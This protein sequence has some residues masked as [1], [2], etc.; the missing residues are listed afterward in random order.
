MSLAVTAHAFPR[1]IVDRLVRRLDR[2]LA[3]FGRELHVPLIAA[4]AYYAGA[5]AAFFVGTLS[6]KIFAPFWPP[7]IVL[8]CALL[9]SPYRRWWLFILAV[10]PAHV[11]AEIRV[12]MDT[13]QLLVAFVTN[14][15]VAAANAA[16]L[17]RMIG[18]PPWFGSLRNA[19]LY[20]LVTAVVSPAVVALGGAFVPIMSAGSADHYWSF[21]AQWY[22]SNAVGSLALGPIALIVL[23]ERKRW[24]R[25][26]RPRQAAEAALLSMAVIIACTIGCMASEAAVSKGFLPALAYLPLPFVLWAALRF[27]TVG[28]SGAVLLVSANSIW[29]ALNGPSLFLTGT[30]ETSVLA[31]QAFIIGLSVPVLL[32]GASIDETRHAEATARESEERMAFSAISANVCLWHIDYK[33]DRFWV[34]NHGRELLGLRPHDVISRHAVMSM[35]HPDDRPEAVAA[36]Q[37]AASAGRLANCEFRIVRPNDGQIRWVRCRARAHGNYRGAPAEISGTFADITEQKTT[38]TE[39]AQQRQEIAHRLRVSMLGE[40]SGG[41][42]HELVQPLSAILSNAEAARI[43]L[44]RDPPDL[45]EVVE[46][47]DDIISENNRASDVINRLRSLLKKSE[48]KFEP[49]DINE[50]VNTT[51]RLLHNEMITRHVR[52]STDL[53]AEPPCVTGDAI[54]LQQVLLNLILNA[55]DAMND[56]VP[57]RRL[58]TVRTRMTDAEQV[59]IEVSD[60]GVGLAPAWQKR[61][62]QPFFTTKE[63]GLG[64]GLSLCSAIVKLH[65]GALSLN[66]NNAGGGAT[67]TFTLPL[68]NRLK[69]AG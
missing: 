40:L 47:L 45:N 42:A 63:R 9:L 24:W 15:A 32:L 64:L 23:S 53:A 6:D 20:I 58:I 37:A 69:E 17:R 7:N 16:A 11:L 19:C 31:L 3:G 65:G 10:F 54:Q 66:N 46:A 28:A 29:H 51:L 56:V 2:H 5:E 26:F 36:L 39:L 67:A 33:S 12:G 13:L 4:L 38:E 62:F 35:I 68:P 59:Q 21:W 61:V 14:C 25:R 48:A 52:V 8:F 27:G 34:T 43:L 50:I 60:C 55:I 22:L 41:I 49:A 30:P 44:T 18:G 1:R 57:A